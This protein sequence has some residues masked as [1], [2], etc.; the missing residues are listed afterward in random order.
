VAGVVD[1]LCAESFKKSVYAK[2]KRA[3][4]AALSNN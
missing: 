1:E 4:E 2:A 3:A